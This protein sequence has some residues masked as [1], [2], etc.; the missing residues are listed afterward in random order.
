MKAAILVHKKNEKM[1]R[2]KKNNQ[3][4]KGNVKPSSSSKAAEML[5]EDGKTG[6]IGFGGLSE[7]M[8]NAFGY[9]PKSVGNEGDDLNIDSEL[10][11]LMRKMGKKDTI[12]RLKAVQEFSEL[13]SRKDSDDVI[14]ILSFWPRI[15]NKLSEDYDHRV[16]EAVQLAHLEIATKAGRTLA[17]QLKI[18]ISSWMKSLFDQYPPAASAAKKSFDTTFPDDKKKSVISF[19]KKDLLVNLYDTLIKQT[20][21]TLSDPRTIPQEER[22]AKYNRL[23]SSSLLSFGYIMEMLQK[24]DISDI[25]EPL[26]SIF[27]E[28]KFWKFSR[29]HSPMIRAAFFNFLSSACRYSAD[30]LRSHT[31]VLCPSV[32]HSLDESEP[33]VISS[34]WDCLLHVVSTFEEC[35]SHVN[36]RKAVF[37]KLWSVLRKG[38]FGCASMVFPSML[39]FISKIPL[40]VIGDGIG[41]ARELF[42][43]M[44][45][46][47]FYEKVASSQTESV[48]VMRAFMECLRYVI[49]NFNHEHVKDELKKTTEDESDRNLIEYLINEEIGCLIQHSLGTKRYFWTKTFFTTFRD[50]LIFIQKYLS[51]KGDKE[52]I[53]NQATTTSH[54][55]IENF[56]VS[57]LN[58]DTENSYIGMKKQ[59]RNLEELIKIVILKMEYPNQRHRKQVGFVKGDKNFDTDMENGIDE[60]T[61]SDYFLP[62]DAKPRHFSDCTKVLLN[63][64]CSNCIRLLFKRRNIIYVEFLSNVVSCLDDSID[65]K[66]TITHMLSVRKCLDIE[67]SSLQFKEEANPYEGVIANIIRPVMEGNFSN[68]ESYWRYTDCQDAVIGLLCKMLKFMDEGEKFGFLKSITEISTKPYMFSRLVQKVLS[69]IDLDASAS[70]FKTCDIWSQLVTYSSNELAGDLAGSEEKIVFS[71]VLDCIDTCLFFDDGSLRTEASTDMLFSIFKNQLASQFSENSVMVCQRILALVAKY[72]SYKFAIDMITNRSTDM[73]IAI[74]Q[75]MTRLDD[76][77]LL[78]QATFTLKRGFSM[79]LNSAG[80]SD[81]GKLDNLLQN[82]AYWVQKVCSNTSCEREIQSLA[83]C[84]GEVICF[85]NSAEV[86]DASSSYSHRFLSQLVNIL[87]KYLQY[88]DF[89]SETSL[90]DAVLLG[91]LSVE[92]LPRERLASKKISCTEVNNA[93]FVAK[94]IISMKEFEV[95]QEIVVNALLDTLCV[96]CLLAKDNCTQDDVDTM[97]HANK[98]ET[99]IKEVLYIE[100]IPSECILNSAVTRALEKGGLH[101][102]ALAKL[103]EILP[104]ST[105]SK[106]PV[107]SLLGKAMSHGENDAPSLNG[108]KVVLSH[109]EDLSVTRAL[110]EQYVDQ[111]CNENSE[112]VKD[113]N[114][115]LELCISAVT[116]WQCMLDNC[117]DSAHDLTTVLQTILTHVIWWKDNSQEALLFSVDL[118]DAPDEQLSLNINLMKLISFSLDCG[119]GK[120][121]SDHSDFILCSLASWIQTCEENIQDLTAS[122]RKMLFTYWACSLC[123]SVCTAF[124]K[125]IEGEGVTQSSNTIL[126]KC[127]C[128]WNIREDWKSMF[129]NQISDDL[130]SEWQEFFTPT[131]FKS[132][133]SLYKV[134]LGC[135]SEILHVKDGHSTFISHLL[136]S[137]CCALTGMPSA[138]FLDIVV[139]NRTFEE[140]LQDGHMPATASDVARKYDDSQI[141]T[142]QETYHHYIN[143]LESEVLC[144][145][146]LAH[147]FLCKLMTVSYS[148]A[149]SLTTE[150]TEGDELDTIRSFPEKLMDVLNT[151][152]ERTLSY[153]E[154]NVAG[155]GTYLTQPLPTYISRYIL[156][157]LLSWQITLRQFRDSEAGRRAAFAN[158]FRKR[159]LVGPL[160]K[161][162]FSI[163]PNDKGYLV[164]EDPVVVEADWLSLNDIRH[165]AFHLYLIAL[166][167][168]PAVIRSW[169][170]NNLDKKSSI[171]TEKFTTAFASPILCSREM[172]QVSNSSKT[173]TNMSIKRRPAAREV[174]AVYSVEEVAMELVVKMSPSHP[175]GPVAVE[176]GK[177]VGV[178]SSQWRHWML[179]L[180]MYLTKQNG[181]IVDGLALWKRNVDKKFEGVEECM[182]CFSVVHGTNYQLP[183]IVCRVC[184]KRFH[185]ACLYKWFNTSNKST[186]PLCRTSF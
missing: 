145:Q 40:T 35:W 86:K 75:L 7:S 92:S 78:E 23:I 155:Y 164:S 61:S 33:S 6:F 110:V 153:L 51:E 88:T 87:D 176:C 47:L 180:T 125:Q 10:R 178:S 135:C 169:C 112:T 108:L 119:G 99:G 60:E 65:F 14:K 20:T 130:V 177:R 185:S 15:Y 26:E 120:L 63:E 136:K 183:T 48:A 157:Y 143:H 43:N 159:N 69:T 103:F 17:P 72:Y 19:C 105:L 123:A 104:E 1:G 156:S 45:E 94:L 81:K 165:L 186:C 132:I 74:F 16:R 174:V 151:S 118:S 117:T 166:E 91:T 109:V 150:S 175:L 25:S 179:Q 152:Q 98:I 83:H 58:S 146:I 137:V 12:T 124:D 142:I 133:Y 121:S 55:V 82:I 52:Y 126:L 59:A 181:T 21:D 67:S 27:E 68:D 95:N 18:I 90:I 73:L 106:F 173:F 36:P 158:F 107:S 96:L 116:H 170:N 22:E 111:L 154:D 9:V 97:P 128:P 77:E 79:L 122:Y 31:A 161:I 29:H 115:A 101:T 134:L 148:V 80:T 3:R 56:A 144:L 8:G 32:L 62:A 93:V 163:L 30:V 160:M 34:F 76:K 140:L 129:S 131:I 44:R 5:V 37:P 54:S 50:L 64:V 84:C 13:C 38:G 162:L 182:I 2:G 127:K 113:F 39:P 28:K 46:G 70:W 167:C 4:T 168:I 100:N 184:K 85:F 102:L 71:S 138:L 11:M 53:C 89:S 114:H 41:F 42:S 66:H 141:G 147:T 24:H 57:L 149:L 139:G 171:I 172:D 49:F